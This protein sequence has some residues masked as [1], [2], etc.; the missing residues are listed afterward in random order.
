MAAGLATC[1]GGVVPA[2]GLALFA[3]V[4]SCTPESNSKCAADSE[5]A[6]GAACLD[7]LCKAKCAA[8]TDCITPP[9][10]CKQAQGTCVNGGCGY[11]VF[12]CAQTE[13]VCQEQTGTCDASL[14]D[15]AC[16]EQECC[17]FAAV[18]K[19]APPHT[20]CPFPNEDTDGDASK[21]PGETWSGR[22]GTEGTCVG[23]T[24]ASQCDDQN[25]CTVDGCDSA[26]CVHED[27]DERT[28]CQVAVADDGQCVYAGS[29][30]TC[31]LAD[32]QACTTAAECA[33]GVC[34]C[35]DGSC[36]A[37]KCAP[38]RCSCAYF[39]S[40]SCVA[41]NDGS[42]E[43]GE[44]G[45]DRERAMAC[46][47]GTCKLI[48]GQTCAQ[49]AD[50]GS[51]Q[52]EC[53][54]AGCRSRICAGAK[55]GEN[56][57]AEGCVCRPAG[58]GGRG[59][60]R[61][62]MSDM[63]DPQDCDGSSSC[64]GGECKADLWASCTADSACA[65]GLC[66]C[67]DAN[68]AARTCQADNCVC[69]FSTP[70]DMFSVCFN[71][72]TTGSR[73]V[74]DCDGASVCSAGRGGGTCVLA[75]GSDAQCTANSNCQSGHCECATADC[76]TRV[77]AAAD[78]DCGWSPTGGCTSPL[79]GSP[80]GQDPQD[81][82]GASA[83]FGV[84]QAGCKL[85]WFSVCTEDAQCGG[86]HCECWDGA[87]CAER[88]CTI[89]DCDCVVASLNG[90]STTNMTSGIP[91]P[92]DCTASGYGCYAG[93]CKK[94]EFNFC[95][96]DSEC[97][98]NNCECTTSSCL[99][100]RCFASSLQCSY[101]DQNA[102]FIPT[103]MNSGA[104]PQDCDG[105]SSCYSYYPGHSACLLKAGATCQANSQCGTQQC[106]CIDE[107]CAARKCAGDCMCGYG[108]EG[109]CSANLARG[110]NDAE[111][112]DGVMGCYDGQCRKDNGV[113]CG[114]DA[115][116]VSGHCEC[117][118]AD[119]TARKCT[120]VACLCKYF[121]G[122]ETTCATASYVSYPKTSS[123]GADPYYVECASR[124]ISDGRVCTGGASLAG[125]NEGRC[126]Y[127]GGGGCIN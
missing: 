29:T 65:S 94:V 12:A 5:C 102:G 35:A 62:A 121:P 83:C 39:S 72:L 51:K 11:E 52:C 89:A 33:N 23:C 6:A 99:P 111:D 71:A 123:C 57:T 42:A 61:R 98:R 47:S 80:N 76:T 54:D 1:R 126:C 78:C 63:K 8:A 41:L 69:S 18:F 43:P 22:C 105:S 53:S 4:I 74:G 117:A 109:A 31:R 26:A 101:Y 34:E 92:Q 45:E 10:G 84:G 24:E 38:L 113:S 77:C 67:A 125:G 75:T 56:F 2:I 70:G 120:Q 60:E 88:R 9:D 66:E 90:C 107:N 28:K 100:R 81:C 32:G 58:E 64:Y 40:G 116:C 106:E 21:D 14:K 59:C 115:Q 46:Y 15:G 44:C 16:K 48:V 96:A 108:F 3:A 37:R 127:Q 36:N 55:G 7:G 97:G 119:C 13:V 114:A 49:D 122:T 93:A 86:G 112:C 79:E 68:C 87:G 50:C 27:T 91:D 17:K 20:A 82:E 95:D 103:I 25:P 104:D 118:N 124:C 19:G 73:D 110:A 85:N 30:I